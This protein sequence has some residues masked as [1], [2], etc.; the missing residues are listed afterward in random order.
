MWEHPPRKWAPADHWHLWSWAGSGAV[1]SVRH[2]QT[3]EKDKERKVRT[4][5]QAL[6]FQES[7]TIFEPIWSLPGFVRD[8][9]LIDV[10]VKARQ[11]PHYFSASCAHHDI[12][13][14][15]IK[16]IN[17]FCLSVSRNNTHNKSPGAAQL[18]KQSCLPS[19]S[20]LGQY[21]S[22]QLITLKALPCLPG[23]GCESVGFWG[24][25]SNRTHIDHVPGQLWHEHF[26]YISA[27]LHAVATSSGAQILHTSDLASKA[28]TNNVAVVTHV[29]GILKCY[30]CNAYISIFKL[31]VIYMDEDKRFRLL[32]NCSHKF[33]L[34]LATKS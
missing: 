25:R 10:F 15:R 3:W 20:T 19:S 2:R 6:H 22:K 31:N 12:R 16:H 33:L 9:L 14:H 11:D 32:A 7:N 24:Q 4:E 17:R 23:S 8:P 29:S 1:S 27:N 30:F 26:L 5:L 21:I 34:V 28:A 13:T 18:T